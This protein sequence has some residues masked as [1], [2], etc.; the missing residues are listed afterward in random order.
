MT[1]ARNFGPAMPSG[2][3]SVGGTCTTPSLPGV[4]I[5]GA[6]ARA[7]IVPVISFPVIGEAGICGI[8]ICELLSRCG[9]AVWWDCRPSGVGEVIDG[10]AGAGM[11][12]A[13][14][15]STGD[16]TGACSSIVGIG[17]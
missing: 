11:R 1:A 15:E 5:A 14:L 16:C 4:V 7:G 3:C 8:A 13:A 17:G 9:A 2:S 6:G 12:G 10:D